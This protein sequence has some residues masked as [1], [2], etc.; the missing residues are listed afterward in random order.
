MEL[1]YQIFLLRLTAHI[2][3]FVFANI[4]KSLINMPSLKLPYSYLAETTRRESK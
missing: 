1:Y 4:Y 3:E 2:F